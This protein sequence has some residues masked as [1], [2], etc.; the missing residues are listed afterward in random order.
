MTANDLLLGAEAEAKEKYEACVAGTCDCRYHGSP[1]SDGRMVL[2]YGH[3]FIRTA[4]G[5]T[6]VV[7]YHGEPV[8]AVRPQWVYQFLETPA[9]LLGTFPTRALC[10]LAIKVRLMGVPV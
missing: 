10:L 1:G 4:N 8:G 9:G 6:I 2:T 5:P 3:G 7:A